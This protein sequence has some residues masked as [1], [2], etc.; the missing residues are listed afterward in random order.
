MFKTILSEQWESLS[1]AVQQHYGIQDGE[2]IS[3]QGKLA[4]KHGRFIK[5]IMPLIRLTGALVPVEGEDF[6][7]SVENKRIGN[8]FY[9]H[10]RFHKNN[11]VY[12]FKSKMQPYKNDIIEFVGLGIG[13]R[14]GLKV[15]E[16]GLVYED[17]GY[18][19][20]L[21]SLLLPIP[22]HLL[23]GKSNIKEFTSKESPHDLEMRFEVNHPWFGFGFSYMG[24][25]NFTK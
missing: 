22:L 5:I 2:E 6:D 11:K 15:I 23:M 3:M 21:G 1:P 13:I 16:G 9:W 8:S 4:V 7:V 24:Y 12:E 10:R 17:K 25:F 20:K 19:F 14:L 18:V